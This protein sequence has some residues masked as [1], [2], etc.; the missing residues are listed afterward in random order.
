ME[1]LLN[2]K[3]LLRELLQQGDIMNTIN[4]GV[5][6]TYMDVQEKE[7]SV[8]IRVFAAGAR[9]KDFKV[10][11]QKNRLSIMRYLDAKKKPKEAAPVFA[12]WFDLPITV[13]RKK[14]EAVYEEGLLQVILPLQNEEDPNREIK[15][16]EN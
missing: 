15:I 13:D 7:G 16:V 1:N 8:V 9:G 2:N 4:G 6:E 10:V 5:S 12:R 11:L 14:I 3:V